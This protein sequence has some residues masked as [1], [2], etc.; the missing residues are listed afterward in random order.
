VDV[1]VNAGEPAYA[2]SG[3]VHRLSDFHWAFIGERRILSRR[4][5]AQPFSLYAGALER[6]S[7]Y[8]P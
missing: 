7:D 8:L 2:E 1:D 3:P 6:P 5:G 4:L